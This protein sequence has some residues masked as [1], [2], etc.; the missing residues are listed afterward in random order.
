MSNTPPPRATSPVSVMIFTLN[1]EIHLP[2]CLASLGWCDDV[3]VIDSFSTDATAQICQSSGVRFFQNRFEGFGTQRN[4]ALDHTAPRHPWVLVLDAD[5]RVPPD[6][7]HELTTLAQ[8]DAPGVGAYRVRRRFHMWGKWLRHSS[9]YPT[10]VVRFIR[11][12]RVRYE[13]RGHAE[14]Q[15]VEGEVRDL[16]CDL[17]DENLKGI[18]EW[19][20]RQNRYSTKDAQ[21][22][23]A[24]R[25]GFDGSGVGW[26][27]LLSGDALER[28]AALKR[29]AAR[30]PA[31]GI[32]YFLYS[33]IWRRGF[34]DGREGF[35]FCRMRAMY[36]TQVALKV[37]DLEQRS[38]H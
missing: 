25:G 30:L 13:N 6:L 11:L 33:Y 26:A 19:F 16:R 38:T 14:T 29:V 24:S 21:F 17:V 22:E 7:A 20:D 23:H 9:L 8:A 28:R 2:H 5:E 31:R 12:G 36:Q 18:D 15:Q 10:W 1:E 34:L 4:W 27:S 35:M 3:I 37:F 32:A